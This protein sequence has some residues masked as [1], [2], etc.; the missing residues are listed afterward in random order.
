MS[1]TRPW[2]CLPPV[3]VEEVGGA[4]AVIALSCVDPR[5]IHTPRAVDDTRTRMPA[6]CVRIWV[7]CMYN[8]HRHRTGTQARTLT[9]TT[10]LSLTHTYLVGECR[11]FGNIADEVIELVFDFVARRGARLARTCLG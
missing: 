2:P 3:V 1:P 11:S 7:P 5:K 6:I 4:K 8:A 10:T 9:D